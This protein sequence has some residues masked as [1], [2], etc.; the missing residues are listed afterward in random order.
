M[1][2]DVN[3]RELNEEEKNYRGIVELLQEAGELSNDDVAKQLHP[4]LF[5]E[6]AIQANAA[7]NKRIL[8]AVKQFGESILQAG[9]A[10]EPAQWSAEVLQAAQVKCRSAIDAFRGTLQATLNDVI[11]SGYVFDTSILHQAMTWFEQKNNL[12]RFGGWWTL[13]S[14]IFWV[15]GIGSLQCVASSRDAQ[16]CR[17]GIGYV[18]DE[19]SLPARDLKSEDG[20]SLFSLTPSRLGQDFFLGYYGRGARGAEGRPRGR[21]AR[22]PRAL[23]ILWRAKTAALQNLC[24]GRTRNLRA[25]V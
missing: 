9:V 24:S 16:V 21:T 15:N 13:V 22:A 1:A 19:R 18:V 6:E 5:S 4:V 11:A 7:R 20:T 3:I 12:D 8:D 14:D 17:K 23:G 2:G 25:G 10:E